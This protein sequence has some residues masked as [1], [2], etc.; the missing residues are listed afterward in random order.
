MVGSL[1][2]VIEIIFYPVMEHRENTRSRGRE[3][4]FS[5]YIVEHNFI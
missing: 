2:N 1:F 3:I 4:L 5:I